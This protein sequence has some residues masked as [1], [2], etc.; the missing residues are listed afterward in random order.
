MNSYAFSK[1][2]IIVILVI[3]VAGGIFAWQYFG[4]PK[5]KAKVP[6]KMEEELPEEEVITKIDKYLH[7][8]AALKEEMTL[9]RIKGVT[10]MMVEAGYFSIS[11][12]EV[13]SFAVQHL[14]T[15]GVKEIEI[16]EVSWIAAPLGGFLIDGKGSFNIGTKHYS[17]FRIGVRDGSEGDA[18]K[19]F[20]FIAR[21]EDEEG[22]VIW[23]PEPG[24][25]FH[26]VEGEVF[27][28]E[29]L[30]YEFLGDREKFESLSSKFR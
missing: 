14:K 1:I 23:Y 17:T 30:V 28:E 25:D 21:G 5:E 9:T 29:F 7:R 11:A 3:L 6:E 19:K 2:W 26:P 4:T 12:P 24:P 22:K 16:C 20:V 18:G 10:P 15:K 8:D 13:L 27:P